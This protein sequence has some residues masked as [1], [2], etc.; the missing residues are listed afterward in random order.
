MWNIRKTGAGISCD[1][2]GNK[3]QAFNR[4]G[5][6]G[7]RLMGMIEI[8]QTEKPNYNLRPMEIRRMPIRAK[9]NAFVFHCVSISFFFI[10]F[11]SMN[12]VGL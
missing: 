3:Y 11:I 5:S 4:S 2:R 9:Q 12:F 6:F 8:K 7:L 1:A 10:S